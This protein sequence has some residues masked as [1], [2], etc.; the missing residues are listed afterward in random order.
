ML[1]ARQGEVEAK[2]V[3]CATAQLGSTSP[4]KVPE[5][6]RDLSAG[7]GPAAQDPTPAQQEILD[8]AVAAAKDS[9]R[10][11][12]GEAFLQAERWVLWII[13][14]VAVAIGLLTLTLPRR[15]RFADVE[16]EDGGTAPQL[17]DADA[18]STQKSADER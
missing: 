2:F 14:A 4:M 9:T 8:D 11:A 16:L 5:Q 1:H 12:A 17:G 18:D 7:A 6:C 13:S 10:S 3:D 15:N